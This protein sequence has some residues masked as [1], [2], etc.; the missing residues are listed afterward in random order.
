MPADPIQVKTLRP[1]DAARWDDFVMHCPQAT[2]FH[3]AGWQQVLERA[4][5]HATWFLYAEIDNR[6]VAVLPLAQVRSTLFGNKLC[7]LPFCV[8]G[9]IAG[10]GPAAQALD[11]AAQ[12][13]AA[14]LRVDHLE[15]RNIMPGHQEWLAPPLYFTFRKELLPQV[16]ANLL[17]IPRKQ[18]A[19]IRKGVAAGLRSEI[20]SETRRFYRLYAASVHRLG[21][22]VPPL[23]YFAILRAVFGSDCEI[24]SVFHRGD[25]VSSV[26]S[27]YFR[28]EVLPYYAGG[29]EA[30]R[31][32]AANDFMYWEVLRRACERGVAR[33]DFGRSKQ[34]TGAFDFK[35][36]WGFT[37]QALHYEYQLHKAQKLV[38]HT[39]ANPRYALFIKAWRRLPLRAANLLGPLIAPSLG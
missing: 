16:E 14:Q 35:K 37:P 3:R 33:F 8:Y 11:L 26:L 39:P 12:R 10:E 30:A 27:F 28:D 34:G 2:F 15:Y 6:I 5:G 4:F 22:P 32:L 7:S 17:A 18:R 19:M 1:E 20:D 13:L 23:R 25:T 21:T 36:N 29:G 24:L 9:G 31:A 38:R